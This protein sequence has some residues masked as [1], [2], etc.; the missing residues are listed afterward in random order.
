MAWLSAIVSNLVLAL[1][2][3]TLA[4]FI[5]RRLRWHGPAHFVWVLVLVKL[6][7]PPLVSVSHDEPPLSAACLN[8]TCGCG[9][10]AFVR[11]RETLPRVLLAVWCAGASATVW[12]GWRRWARFRRLLANAVPAPREWQALAAC[13]A[14]EL[15]IRR[16]PEILA[17]PGRL[18]PF[19]L[20]GG[21]RPRMLLPAELIGQL[22]GSQRTTLLLHELVH[23]KRRDHLLRAIELAVSI[24]YWWLPAVRVIRRR[25]RACEEACCDA[26]VVAHR[27]QARRDYARLLLDVLDFVAPAPCAVETA[28]AMSSAHDLERRLRTILGTSP[29]RASRLWPAGAFAVTL[30]CAVVPCG[31]R[32]D[33]ARWLVPQAQAVTRPPSVDPTRS[34]LEDCDNNSSRVL[35]CPS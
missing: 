24:A 1:L 6:V 17:V 3:A 32:Y 30:A 16:P 7:M 2:L 22:D 33:F 8:G 26:T 21:V 23:I 20:P 19:V 29:T 18:P 25:L 28:T 34:S 10:H 13:L 11:V 12:A 35:C 5:E 31:M 4:W 9:P 14:G 27:P 15:A